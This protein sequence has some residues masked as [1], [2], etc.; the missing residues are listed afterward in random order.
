MA[1][2]NQFNPKRTF[3]GNQHTNEHK[4]NSRCSTSTSTDSVK[5]I[6]NM[7]EINIRYPNVLGSIGRSKASGKI[8]SAVMNLSPPNTKFEKYN[9]KLLA[10]VTEG[11]E[12]SMRHAANKVTRMR[13][14][15]RRGCCL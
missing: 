4:S 13:R 15:I 12:A 6:R 11:C 1:R 3:R 14:K 10:A 7:Y 9:T 8:F 2:I 5:C